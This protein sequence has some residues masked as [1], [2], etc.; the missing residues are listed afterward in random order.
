MANAILLRVSF[1]ERIYCLIPSYLGCYNFVNMLSSVRVYI[2]E[3]CNAK[4]PNCFNSKYRGNSQMDLSQ[5]S[6]LCEYFSSNNIKNIKIMGG[7]PT[8]H[9]EFSEFLKIAQSYFSSVS[10]FTN[11][12]NSKVTEFNPRETDSIIYNFKFSKAF[13]SFEKLLLDKPG[14]RS[15]E[16]QITTKTD[17]NQ[18]MSELELFSKINSKKITPCLTLDCTENIFSYRNDL[19]QKY[20]T[21]WDYCKEIGFSVGQD[22]LIPLCFIKGSNIPMSI[23]G[24]ICSLNCAGLIDSNYQIKYCNQFSDVLGL[25][26]K[27]NGDIN[28]TFKEYENLLISKHIDIISKSLIKGCEKCLFWDKYCN[29]GCFTAK[30]TISS[31]SILQFINTI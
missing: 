10:L 13:S 2:T 9:P 3:N 30:D 6:K 1:P 23:N 17:I 19:I 27:E 4:C 18:L 31:D 26:I 29:G 7:E 25:L 14:R 15:L 5:F 22:H 28:F 8:T 11:A 20:K 12:I 16:I 24:A 21:I